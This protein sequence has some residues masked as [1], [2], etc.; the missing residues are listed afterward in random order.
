MARDYSQVNDI[1]YSAKAD[2]YSRQ[3]L[4]LDVY[5]P[6]GVADCPVPKLIRSGKRIAICDKLET[7]AA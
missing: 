1:Q 3:Q 2:E 6:Q 7:S 4:K 5:Y